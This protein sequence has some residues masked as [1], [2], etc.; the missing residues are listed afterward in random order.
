MGF[1]AVWLMGIWKRSPSGKKISEE[2]VDLYGDYANSLPDWKPEDLPGSPYCIMDYSIDPFFGGVRT[3]KT[4]RKAL[5]KLG[6]LLILD[7]VPNHVAID[8]PW[9]KTNPE[10]FVPG[11][12]VDYLRAPRE[13][14]KTSTGVFANG[15]DPF[16][17][18]WKDVVQLNAFSKAYRN[19]AIDELKKMGGLCDGVRCDMAMLMLNRVFCY[20]WQSRGGVPAET[21]FWVDVISATKDAFPEMIFI[22]EVYWGLEWDL[23]Q[24]GFDYCYDKRL[25]DRIIHENSTTIRQHLQADFGFQ[26]RLLRFLENHDENR[27]A[28]LMTEEKLR[29]AS[30]LT[31]SL[32]GAFLMYEGQWDGRRRMNHVLL[33]RRQ[34]EPLNETI[35]VF[36]KK[37]NNV[38]QNI[39]VNG[40][41]F[42]CPV[43]T[44]P[45]NKTGEDLITFGWEN[46]DKKQLIVVNYSD[47]TS[48]GRLILPWEDLIELDIKMRDVFT[49]EIIIRKG[50]EIITEGLFV[51]LPPWG[52]HWFQIQ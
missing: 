38:S 24:T 25:Y 1:T 48:Q 21:E 6:L 36:Y 18:P 27:A 47:H 22:A 26:T 40:T 29:A 2:N 50:R 43:S 35:R 41:W 28:S 31:A 8:H 33:G 51:N 30:I 15:R 7:F 13:F 16:F 11:D 32:P 49:D 3:L 34:E 14:L 23:M 44:W 46:A 42:L 19:A 45:D 20:T 10:Y 9:L 17:P 52:F 37:L 5:N 4:V 12:E 39:P